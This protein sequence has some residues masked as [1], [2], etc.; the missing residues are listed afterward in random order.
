MDNSLELHELR[1]AWKELDQRLRHQQDLNLQLAT[2]DRVRRAKARLWPLLAGQSLQALAGVAMTVFFARFWIAHLHEPLALA[3]GLLM[4]AW[5]V[6]L[7]VSAV[8]ELLLAVR[9]NYA[10]PVLTIQK[11]L[12]LL[13]YWRTRVTPLLG[14]AFWVLW[15]PLVEVLAKWATGADIGLRFMAW[16]LAVGIAGF[17]ATLWWFR[18]LRRRASRIAD[19]IDADNAGCGVQGA[20]ALLAEIRAFERP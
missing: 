14:L 9:I 18:H 1:Q 16:N 15:L 5:S 8:V 2:G 13:R 12:G 19:A 6:A 3:C 17:A 4:H 10:Q 11:Y 7:V 20:E